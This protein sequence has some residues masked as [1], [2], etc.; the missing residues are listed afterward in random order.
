M[1]GEDWWATVGV[2]KSRA[3]V[4]GVTEQL[5]RLLFFHPSFLPTVLSSNITSSEIPFSN[6]PT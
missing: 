4:H 1:D 6:Y 2:T 5:T 3:T